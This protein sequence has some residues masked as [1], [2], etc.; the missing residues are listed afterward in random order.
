MTTSVVLL[1]VSMNVVEVVGMVEVVTTTT[2]AHP[3]ATKIESVAPMVVVAVMTTLPVASIATLL[4]DAMTATL[5]A[6]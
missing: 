5:A 6:V 4:L 2:V 1:V 3:L